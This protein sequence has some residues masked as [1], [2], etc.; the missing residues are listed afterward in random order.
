MSNEQQ[1]YIVVV[2]DEARQML[3]S[4]VRFL[5]NVNISAARKLKATLYKA[6]LSLETM[7]QRC[8]IYR[9]RRT[10]ETYRQLIL[11]RYQII[12]SIDDERNTVSICYIL[13]SRQDY[14]SI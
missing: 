9:T 6:F 13:D 3:Y 2:Y 7:P 1:Q 12:F 4:H 14:D 5:A 8:P 11:G 10:S